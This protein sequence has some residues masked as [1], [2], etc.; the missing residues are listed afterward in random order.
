MEGETQWMD[1]EIVEL[2]HLYELQ[3]TLYDVQLEG[4]RIREKKKQLE[5]EIGEKLNKPGMM[6]HNTAES[7]TVI[8]TINF[9]FDNVPCILY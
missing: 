5:A 2:I 7:A 1:G 3:R 6:K 8:P 4:Y 9:C